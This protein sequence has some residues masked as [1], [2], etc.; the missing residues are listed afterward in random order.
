ML[1][2]KS[3]ELVGDEAFSDPYNSGEYG[4]GTDH[5]AWP[6][7]RKRHPVKQPIV[8]LLVFLANVLEET[9]LKKVLE[10]AADRYVPVFRFVLLRCRI[11]AVSHSD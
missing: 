4:R 5:R 11:H 7:N 3:T 6:L 1:A 10:D 9:R 2:P 8:K